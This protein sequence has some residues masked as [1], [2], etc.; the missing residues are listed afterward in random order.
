MAYESKV[1]IVEIHRTGFYTY[2][3]RIAEVRLSCMGYDNGW[4]KLFDKEIDYQLYMDDGNTLFDEDNYGEHL[5]S[6][7]V[8]KVIGWLEQEMKHNDYRRLPILYN[9]LKPFTGGEWKNV[10]VVH[11]GY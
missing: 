8:D 1:F 11:F 10:E 5:K 9:V 6:C 2:A 4:K 7:S 3:E